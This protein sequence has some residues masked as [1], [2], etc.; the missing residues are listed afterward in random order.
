MSRPHV[1]R[2]SRAKRKFNVRL[3]TYV[4]L[5]CV[6]LLSVLH[7]RRVLCLLLALSFLVDDPTC[8][9]ML[10]IQPDIIK[11]CTQLLRFVARCLPFFFLFLFF[12][13]CVILQQQPRRPSAQTTVQQELGQQEGG[14]RT[15]NNRSTHWEQDSWITLDRDT[16]ASLAPVPDSADSAHELASLLSTPPFPLPLLLLPLPPCFPPSTPSPPP[17]LPCP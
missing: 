12:F 16:P 13:L 7:F 2:F 6:F 17:F 15:N 3:Y 1:M 5:A 14:A 8:L 11:S 4:G 10:F 9:H